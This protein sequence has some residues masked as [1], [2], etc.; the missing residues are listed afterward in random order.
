MQ[1]GK[2][3]FCLFKQTVETIIVLTFTVYIVSETFF[4]VLVNN[5]TYSNLNL[6]NVRQCPKKL[7][8]IL[9]TRFL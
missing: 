5:N 6:Q 1:A 4:E 8:K 9:F 2:R 7:G 3:T